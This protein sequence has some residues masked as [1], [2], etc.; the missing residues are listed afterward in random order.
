MAKSIDMTLG[1][2]KEYMPR[3]LEKETG[4]SYTSYK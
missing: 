4:C 2:V 1:H 3:L